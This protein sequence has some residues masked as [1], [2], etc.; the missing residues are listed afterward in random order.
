MDDFSPWPEKWKASEEENEEP[1]GPVQ[2]DRIVEESEVLRLDEEPG[3][4]GVQR[5]YQLAE[6]QLEL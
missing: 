2:L 5:I 4:I 1:T 6:V 3:I